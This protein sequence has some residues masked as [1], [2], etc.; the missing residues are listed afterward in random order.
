MA[1]TSPSASSF[2]IAYKKMNIA[3]TKSMENLI[4]DN[5]LSNVR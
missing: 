3:I 5:I 4:N 1:M 2:T